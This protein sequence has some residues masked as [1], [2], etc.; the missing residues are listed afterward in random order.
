MQ[1]RDTPRNKANGT[2]SKLNLKERTIMNAIKQAT[3][4]LT[5]SVGNVA[6]AATG[7][8]LVTTKTLKDVTDVTAQSV[9]GLPG[10]LAALWHTPKNA[11]VGYVK[12]AEECTTT[13]AQ[14]KVDAMLPDSLASGIVASA[15]GMG[16]LAAL[17]MEDELEDEQEAADSKASS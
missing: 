13:E 15:M 6:T 17:L 10:V 5:S 14:A 2:H 8:V 12:E 11:M 4:D 1:N 7:V 16:A 9:E 3:R